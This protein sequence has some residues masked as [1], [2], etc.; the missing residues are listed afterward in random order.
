MDARK[1]KKKKKKSSVQKKQDKIVG[2][3]G[4][5]TKSREG[6]EVTTNQL[7]KK[8]GFDSPTAFIFAVGALSQERV[9]LSKVS[10]LSRKRD[11]YTSSIKITDGKY[12]RA[13]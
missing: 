6:H 11:N 12:L 13:T 2:W 9:N 1:K 10:L 7:H 3:E 5:T 4:I 8:F